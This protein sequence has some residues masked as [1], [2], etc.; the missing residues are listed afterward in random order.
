MH[1]LHKRLDPEDAVT[2]IWL[3]IAFFAGSF[4]G[5]LVVALG[6]AAREPMPR[7]AQAMDA[8]FA[9]E[10]LDSRYVA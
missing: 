4:F 3:A 9:D 1:R 10:T 6:W 5:V 2:I 7:P 8:Q